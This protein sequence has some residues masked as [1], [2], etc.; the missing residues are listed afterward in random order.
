MSAFT[1]ALTVVLIVTL[2]SGTARGGTVAG[3]VHAIGL[4]GESFVLPGVRLTLRC[5][6]EAARTGVSDERG[7]FKFVGVPA[8]SCA[9]ETDIQGFKAATASFNSVAADPFDVPISLELE[10]LDT[11]L[12]VTS[13][14]LNGTTNSYCQRGEWH[15]VTEGSREPA[16]PSGG[17]VVH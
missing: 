14:R 10:T 13:R 1:R 6:S 4:E 12:T 11:G 16:Q 9:L 7:E 2:L 5:G 8:A 3:A 17:D 15:V